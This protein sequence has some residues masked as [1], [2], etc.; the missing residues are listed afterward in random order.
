MQKFCSL[1]K[2]QNPDQLWFASTSVAQQS[3]CQN[4]YPES[5]VQLSIRKELSTYQNW[6]LLTRMHACFII[7][8][9]M[10]TKNKK[11]IE[12]LNV[13]PFPDQ[14]GIVQNSYCIQY[15]NNINIKGRYS[16]TFLT[17]SQNNVTYNI[18][19]KKLQFLTK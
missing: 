6:V 2:S 11:N 17:E 15:S 18:K 13:R 19:G 4:I 7:T 14:T 10:K 12:F 1:N 16:F 5:C 9:W 3:I 8:N